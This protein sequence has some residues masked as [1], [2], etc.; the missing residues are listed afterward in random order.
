MIMMM[1]FVKRENERRICRER[2]V[3][4]YETPACSIVDI[5]LGIVLCHVLLHFKAILR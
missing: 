5:V 4:K 1:C 3:R 2:N